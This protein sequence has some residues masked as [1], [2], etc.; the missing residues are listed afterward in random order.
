MDSVGFFESAWL[1][2]RTP[3]TLFH[4]L[5]SSLFMVPDDSLYWTYSLVVCLSL[6]ESGIDWLFIKGITIGLYNILAYEAYF[7][8]I[9]KRP[10]VY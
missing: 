10:R 6:D 7:V 4:I 2:F 1:Y 3:D 9:Y 5:V 8:L